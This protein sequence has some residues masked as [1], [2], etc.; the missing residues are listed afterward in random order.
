MFGNSFPQLVIAY[1]YLLQIS[2]NSSSSE[3]H[4]IPNCL[5][6]ELPNRRIVKFPNCQINQ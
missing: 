4:H 2:I 5:I 3:N 6:K 1:L